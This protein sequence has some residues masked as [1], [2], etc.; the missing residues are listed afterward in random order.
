MW[1]LTLFAFAL[2]EILVSVAFDLQLNWALV[3]GNTRRVFE[4]RYYA[5]DSGRYGDENDWG[6]GQAVPVFLLPLPISTC[7]EALYGELH[8]IAW[9]SLSAVH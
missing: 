9:L 6:F 1:C 2:K 7:A 3:L 4:T 8:K 5:S